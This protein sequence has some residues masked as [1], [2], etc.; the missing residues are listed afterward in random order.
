MLRIERD[1]VRGVGR[2][3]EPMGVGSTVRRGGTTID[4]DAV[5]VGDDVDRAVEPSVSAGLSSDST[6]RASTV[7]A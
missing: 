4:V 3:D 1:D 5:T 2:D 6:A 7:R